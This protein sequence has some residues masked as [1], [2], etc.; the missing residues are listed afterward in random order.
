MGVYI[1]LGDTT[2]PIPV[3]DKKGQKIAGDLP[4]VEKYLAKKTGLPVA[5]V[6]KALSPDKP[7][8]APA[9]DDE[10]EL[11]TKKGD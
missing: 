1:K 3:A 6:R 10:G 7:E 5:E 9:G 8:E 2:I 4:A 11:V